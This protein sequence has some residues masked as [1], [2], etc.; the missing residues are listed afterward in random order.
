MAILFYQLRKLN[1]KKSLVVILAAGLVAGLLSSPFV[2][3][4][5]PQF[6]I[7][8]IAFS[9]TLNHDMPLI[10]AKNITQGIGYSTSQSDHD[11]GVPAAAGDIIEFSIYYHNGVPNTDANVANNALVRASVIPVGGTAA[12]SHQFG[13]T[14]S[15]SNAAA[16]TASSRGGDMV[17]NIQGGQALPLSYIPGSTVLY[18]DRGSASPPAPQTMPDSIFDSGVNIGSVRGCFE[19]HGFV[20]FRVRIGQAAAAGDLQ[21]K[22]YVRN[23]TTGSGFEDTQVAAQPGQTVEYKIVTTAVNGS[24]SNVQVRDSALERLTLTGSVTLDG[25]AVS[26][27]ELFGSGVSLGTMTAVTSRTILFQ[28]VVAGAGSF[29]SGITTNLMDTATALSGSILKQDEAIVAV[30]REQTQVVCTFTYDTPHVSDGSGRGLRRVG[31]LSNTREQVT[32]LQPDASFNIKNVHVSGSPT[33]RSPLQADASGNYLLSKDT[34]VISSGY[35]PGDYNSYIEIGSQ[36]VATCLGFRIEQASVQQ[37]DIDKTIR[38]ENTG[39][40]FSDSVDAQPGHR[41]TFRLT[42]SPQSSNTTLQNVMVR[43][44]LPGRMAY[45]AGTLNVNGQSRSDGDFFG[46]SGINIGSIAPGQ[47]IPVTFQ[48]DIASTA[49]FTAGQCESLVNTGYVSA[50]GGLSDWD[51][52]TA[53]VCKD[54]ITK[55]PG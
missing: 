41:V 37:I 13:A 40:G 7:F 29:T 55:Q 39:A 47:Q 36:N 12:M 22:K 45:V 4:A 6:N 30:T 26:A 1:L 5:G 34:T 21:V 44:G 52:A 38:N 14:I 23:V 10:D 27:T 3:A 24:V 54:Q 19:F 33:F 9:P 53:R 20:N 8:P 51:T 35:T 11:N 2:K 46:A 49:N 31:D 50:S 16:V 42:V 48:A 28:A 15:A 18:K 17:V 43:E 32:G 25:A